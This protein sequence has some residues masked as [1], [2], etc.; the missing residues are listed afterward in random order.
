MDYSIIGFFLELEL[1]EV[2]SFELGITIVAIALWIFDGTPG[3]ETMVR[4]VRRYRHGS[5]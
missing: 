1:A 3:T 4:F 5:S 2:V